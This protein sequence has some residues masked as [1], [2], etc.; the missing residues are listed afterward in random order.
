[1]KKRQPSLWGIVLLIAMLAVSAC[2]TSVD[3]T[4]DGVAPVSPQAPAIQTPATSLE[5]ESTQEP[6][7]S[8]NT[9]IPSHLLEHREILFVT[10]ERENLPV[11]YRL[12]R[13]SG[14]ELIPV[15]S[16]VDEEEGFG[17]LAAWNSQ[18]IVYSTAS[19][20]G[21]ETLW[22]TTLEDGHTRQV[23]SS[24]F[25]SDLPPGH[26]GPA[27]LLQF[28]WLPDSSGVLF[29]TRQPTYGPGFSDDLHFVDSESGAIVT[30]LPA[31]EGGL[32]EFSPDGKWLA[33]VSPTRI[34]LLSAAT[35]EVLNTFDHPG[36]STY[37]SYS[38][39]A[40]LLWLA[41]SSGVVAT[42]PPPE[43]IRQP[44][45]IQLHSDGLTRLWQ[46]PADGTE[47]HTLATLAIA[48]DQITVSPNLRHVIYLEVVELREPEQN[49]PHNMSRARVYSHS[50]ETDTDSLLY[51][52]FLPTIGPWLPDGESLLI[53]VPDMEPPWQRV[54]VAQNEW[55][56]WPF[57]IGSL[58][59]SGEQWLDDKHFLFRAGGGGELWLGNIE[60]EQW[61]LFRTEG[62]ILK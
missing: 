35:L 58:D 61:L 25:L 42:I 30:I 16:V 60:G 55:S 23:L 5:T 17:F 26:L 56:P 41:D 49:D 43:G 22:L 4:G 27:H 51:E 1:M 53:Q 24:T 47:L 54:D 45:G 8:D 32:F 12:W 7:A 6:Q 46:I 36:V 48:A 37:S 62:F 20:L 57:A 29:N 21:F 28:E 14:G 2:V 18:A 50:L 3:N 31:G 13:W 33:V 59:S 10:T 38:F 11:E 9:P 15:G 19:E 40:P 34:Q 44:T 39:Y 52:G